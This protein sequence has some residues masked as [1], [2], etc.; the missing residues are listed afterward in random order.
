MG[1]LNL[2]QNREVKICTWKRAS[3]TLQFLQRHKQSD[4]LQYVRRLTAWSHEKNGAGIKTRF[5]MQ[6]F[7]VPGDRLPLPVGRF[8]LTPHM[9]WKQAELH[10]GYS[11][12]AFLFLGGGY[13][14]HLHFQCYPKSPTHAPPPTPRPTNSH[15]LALLLPC[16]E[17]YKVCKTNGPLF[18]LM[19]N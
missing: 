16:T 13:L 6:N 19:A 12:C 14:F 17:A 5:R 7:T 4:A 9:L 1:K 11:H 10:C 18:P 8:T 15:F 3:K 2:W